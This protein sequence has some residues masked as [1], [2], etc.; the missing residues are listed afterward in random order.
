MEAL[1]DGNPISMETCGR[2]TFVR[3]RFNLLLAHHREWEWLWGL[4]ARA[5]RPVARNQFGGLR[6][7]SSGGRRDNIRRRAD[8][9]KDDRRNFGRDERRPVEREQKKAPHLSSRLH[10]QERGQSCADEG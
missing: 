9:D 3:L 5:A 10:K 8:S 7:K 6:E 4:R 1:N 2:K